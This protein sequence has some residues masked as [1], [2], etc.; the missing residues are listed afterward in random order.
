MLYTNKKNLYYPCL[1]QKKK[2]SPVCSLY[3]VEHFLCNFK[4]FVKCLK[5]YQILKW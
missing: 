5:L 2:E 4:D 3:E 1:K